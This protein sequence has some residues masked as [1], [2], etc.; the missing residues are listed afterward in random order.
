M[1]AAP[2][3]A[4][5]RPWMRSAPSSSQCHS[6]YRRSCTALAVSRSAEGAVRRDLI[7]ISSRAAVTRRARSTSAVSS[8]STG[9]RD[10]ARSFE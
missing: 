8:A 7:V 4:P 3:S 10:S 2:S 6:M 5:S 1:S 9:A